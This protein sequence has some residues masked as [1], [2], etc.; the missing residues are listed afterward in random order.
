[1]DKNFKLTDRRRSLIFINI[2]ISCIATSMLSTALTTALPAII[3]DFDITANTGQW[4]T[5]GYS[6]AMGIVM[7]L[8]AFLITR[9]STRKLYISGLVIFTTGLFINLF[10]PNFYIMMAAR[11]LQACGNGIVTALAQVV[12]LSI[13][14]VEKRG[15]VMGWYGLSI[16]AAPVIAPTLAGMAVDTFGWHSIFI[17][18]IAIIG[19]SLAVAFFVFADVLETVEKHFD[20]ISFV[21]SVFAFGG[22]T[23][24]LGNIGAAPFMSLQTGGTLIVGAAAAVMFTVRQFRSAQ[25]FLDLRVVYS[26]Q[27]RMSLI[28]SMILYL[29]MMGS[30]M[31]MPLYVQSVMGCS[32][33]VSGLVTLP[34]SLVMAF[35]SPFA[36]KL[37]DRLGMRMLFII[38]SVCMLTGN[39]AMGLISS[40]TSVWVAS[41][42]NCIRC[43]AIGCLLMPFV[44]WGVGGVSKDL[45]AHASALL[46]SLRTVAG[47]VG[48][49]VFVSIMSYVTDISSASYGSDAA[50]HGLNVA[51]LIMSAITVVMLLIGIFAV[52]KPASASDLS[53]E[54]AAQY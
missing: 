34:G 42:F 32:A 43:A 33:T 54:K 7:P 6:L 15:T 3:A 41:A 45:T 30:S 14:P 35:V 26:R 9:F 22:I 29:I 20:F 1:M 49:A 40:E 36:G 47:A 52:K 4:L 50:M 23:L 16:G 19:C 51:Y 13:Y 18:A 28:S 5:S 38:G 12:I 21:M 8:T 39:L 44:T 11:I 31:L 53:A 10:A 48:I 25:P 37:Y 2:V 27:F 24:G 17:A 46:T